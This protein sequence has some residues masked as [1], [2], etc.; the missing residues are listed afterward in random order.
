MSRGAETSKAK[1]KIGLT[2]EPQPIKDFTPAKAGV[3]RQ[4]P[5]TAIGSQ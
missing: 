2:D 4:P 3:C 1:A 5:E